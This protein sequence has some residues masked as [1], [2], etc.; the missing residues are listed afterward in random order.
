MH[1]LGSVAT[2]EASQDSVVMQAKVKVDLRPHCRSLNDAYA[3]E[4][5]L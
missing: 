1:R 5:S 3:H 2:D 4:T